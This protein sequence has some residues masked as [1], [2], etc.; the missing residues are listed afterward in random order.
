[1]DWN[2]IAADE[3][4]GRQ[5][6]EAPVCTVCR[7]IYARRDARGKDASRRIMYTHILIPNS[8][9]FDRFEYHCWR[10]LDGMGTDRPPII[11]PGVFVTVLSGPGSSERDRSTEPRVTTPGCVHC[12]SRHDDR[13]SFIPQVRSCPCRCHWYD[14]REYGVN[15]MKRAEVVD[16]ARKL[17]D[18]LKAKH[19]ADADG[20]YCEG[21]S[22]EHRYF[23]VE[24]PCDVIQLINLLEEDR[25]V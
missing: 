19:T 23:W 6:N 24:A 13:P 16:P 9:A 17:I 2:S 4:K 1:M 21:C 8:G 20:R 11:P 10:T 15:Q 18:E 14:G 12:S 22:D 7:M 5:P 3:M 25:R